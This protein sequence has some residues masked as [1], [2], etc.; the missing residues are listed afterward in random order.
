[1]GGLDLPGRMG[2]LLYAQL[3]E[4]FKLERDQAATPEEPDRRLPHDPSPTRM[5]QRPY[6]R[7]GTRHCQWSRFQRH[8][9]SYDPNLASSETSF[10]FIRSDTVLSLRIKP[11]ILSMPARAAIL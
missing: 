4:S 8:T 7:A 3:T 1:M 10:G 6:R 9:L 5:Q 2:L 11:K